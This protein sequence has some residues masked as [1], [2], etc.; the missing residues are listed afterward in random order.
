MFAGLCSLWD[1]FSTRNR[2][3]TKVSLVTIHLNTPYTYP[4]YER[5]TKLYSMG[6]KVDY[7]FFP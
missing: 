5:K 1:E 2:G 7:S 6:E 4:Y 3:V